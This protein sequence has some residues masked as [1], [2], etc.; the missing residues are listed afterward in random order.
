MIAQPGVAPSPALAS[1]LDGVPTSACSRTL[2]P[3]LIETT[4]RPFLPHPRQ[5]SRPL[6]RIERTRL[7]RPP[8]CEPQRNPQGLSPI[9]P[10]AGRRFATDLYGL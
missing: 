5:R 6:M 2:P 8:R 4:A 7:R 1:G 3:H 9:G 10:E